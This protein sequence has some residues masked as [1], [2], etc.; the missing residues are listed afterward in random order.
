MN[1]KFNKIPSWVKLVST[2]LILIVIIIKLLGY[3]MSDLNDTLFLK[4]LFTSTLL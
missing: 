3:N 4:N 1:L 2:I